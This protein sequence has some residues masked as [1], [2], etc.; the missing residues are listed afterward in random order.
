MEVALAVCLQVFEFIDCG[1][2]L[3]VE[4]SFSCVGF[5]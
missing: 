5:G 2:D 4:L 1:F 3:G